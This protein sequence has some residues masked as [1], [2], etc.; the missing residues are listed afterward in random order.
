MQ[1]QDKCLLTF[2][3]AV[4]SADVPFV[5]VHLHGSPAVH[6][7]AAMMCGQELNCCRTLRVPY[8]GPPSVPG[9]VFGALARNKVVL[10]IGKNGVNRQK[11][12]CKGPPILI[13]NTHPFSKEEI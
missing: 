9:T 7:M 2:V 10:Y 4:G 13:T 11:V 1:A 6:G 5:R 3:T 12:P 8:I